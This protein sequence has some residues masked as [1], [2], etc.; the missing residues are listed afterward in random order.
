MV[1]LHELTLGCSFEDLLVEVYSLDGVD[2]ASKPSDPAFY[3]TVRDPTGYATLVYRASNKCQPSN[4]KKGRYYLVSGAHA[5]RSSIHHAR[6]RRSGGS[7]A[8]GDAWH[9]TRSQLSL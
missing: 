3:A 7:A 1:R 8:G 4:V 6:C 2:P 5:P 9:D